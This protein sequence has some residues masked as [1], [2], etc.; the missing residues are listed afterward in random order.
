MIRCLHNLENGEITINIY[1]YYVFLFIKGVMDCTSFID[2]VQILLLK[3]MVYLILLAACQNPMKNKFLKF[4]FS[5][6]FP[7]KLE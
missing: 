5:M 7:L 1:I 6:I 3:C 4:H 2:I